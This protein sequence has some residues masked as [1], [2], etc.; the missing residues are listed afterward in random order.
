MPCHSVLS[1]PQVKAFMFGSVPLKTYL[2]DGDIDLSVFPSGT[3][4]NDSWT[5]KLSAALEAEGRNPAALYRIR[6]VQVIHAEVDLGIAQALTSNAKWAGCVLTKLPPEDRAWHC[7]QQGV[8][9]FPRASLMA[10][11]G[12]PCCTYRTSSRHWQPAQPVKQFGLGVVELPGHPS[13][14]EHPV[15]CRSSC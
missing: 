4:L 3:S 9:P 1:L 6:D 5:D 7:V 11:Q 14:C 15:F 8:W 12:L 2:P 13:A 10:A